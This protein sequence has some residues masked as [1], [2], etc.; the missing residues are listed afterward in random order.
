[1]KIYEQNKIMQKGSL[2]VEALALLGLITMV[3]P[4][5]YKKAAERTTE[6]QDINIATQMRTLNEALDNYVRN[7]YETMGTIIPT[8]GGTIT[9]KVEDGDSPAT[10]E[11]KI[12]N[13]IKAYLPVGFDLT[14]SKY[15][16]ADNLQFTIKRKDD[17]DLEGV[18]RSV[19][20]SAVMAPSLNDITYNRASKIASMIGVNGGTYRK[21]TSKFE[22]AQGVWNATPSDWFA[23]TDALKTGSLMSISHAAVSQSAQ[24]DTSKLLYRVDDGDESKNTMGTNLFMGG[25]DI[26]GIATLFGVGA[27]ED[28]EIGSASRETGLIVQGATSLKNALTVEGDAKFDN[29]VDVGTDLAVA[30][31][32]TMTGTLGVSGATTL[33]GSLTVTDDPTTLGG[34][35]GVTGA[36][37]LDGSLTVTDDPTTL[38]GTLDVTGATTLGSTLDVTG[39]TTLKDFLLVQA[40]AEIEG[41]LTVQEIDADRL[42]ANEEL[43]VGG[44]IGSPSYLQANSDG[45]W[46]KGGNNEIGVD[47]SAAYMKGGDYNEIKVDATKAI[48]RVNGT[49]AVA[50]EGAFEIRRANSTVFGAV[51]S[52]TSVM[53]GNSNLLLNDSGANLK[54]GTNKVGVESDRIIANFNET[55]RL[56]INS[57]ESR[58]S[59][60]NSDLKLKEDLALLGKSDAYIKMYNNSGTIN[61]LEIVSDNMYVGANGLSLGYKPGDKGDGYFDSN[62]IGNNFLSSASDEE[63]VISRKGYID[64][65]PPSGTDDGLDRGFIRARRLV[66]D[67]RY[68]GIFDG[69]NVG[70]SNPSTPYQYYEVNPAYTS[71]MND[72]KLASRGGARLSDILPDYVVKGIYVADNTYHAGFEN[73]GSGYW[74]D[75][76]DF[77]K[78]PIENGSPKEGV[79]DSSPSGS[80]K[81]NCLSSSSCKIYE[82][83][84]A[85]CVASPWL[86]F[87]PRPQCPRGYQAVITS[88]PIRWRMSEIYYLK[89]NIHDFMES[90]NTEAIT[91]VLGDY[92]GLPTA[93][94]GEAFN[95]YFKKHTDPY[96][97]SVVIDYSSAGGAHNHD[98]ISQ[99]SASAGFNPIPTFQTNT[100]LN[101]AVIPHEN[102]SNDVDGWHVLMGFIYREDQYA[103]LLR[104]RLEY[105]D[106]AE[107]YELY[108]NVF[109]VHAQEMASIV[110]TYCSFSRRYGS[111]WQWD[112]DTNNSD[113]PVLNYD[114]L[115]PIYYRDPTGLNRSTVSGS[116]RAITD[117]SETI[118]DPTLPYDDAW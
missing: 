110:T 29:K 64:I 83:K 3:T 4:V 71:V 112:A 75:A 111:V 77:E 6:L 58:L 2:M 118:N 39:A 42:H 79:I 86:G 116:G 8:D 47:S 28:I 17:V 72:I 21:D 99:G 59:A 14:K 19:Y 30:G 20:T 105:P 62:G 70:G 69:A 26:D 15:F 101:S 34:T 10:N 88:S 33:D 60:G 76:L 106:N 85:D 51:E 97:A 78:I 100:W 117:W 46:A 11:G 32:T 96:D 22:G 38:G 102:S 73:I 81:T 24:A 80:D 92:Y 49:D 113:S 54:K 50:S 108:W 89:D 45:F 63:V 66:S 74:G 109:P 27:A 56:F 52:E 35:L 55:D 1:M 114:Q 7:N 41:I 40:D 23:D 25:N 87:V 67:V 48:F 57:D 9:V 61:D 36:T 43:T 16:N 104:D 82:C 18:V 103:T 65:A 107:D 13:G 53:Y 95:S 5:M 37:T 98:I 93:Y 84:H 44:V 115:D 91:H 90:G 31:N 12:I 68:P 94:E